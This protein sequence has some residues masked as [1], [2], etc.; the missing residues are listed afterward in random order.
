MCVESNP[1]LP[2]EHPERSFKGGL[3]S[4][5]KEV[6][7]ERARY[8]I[9]QEPSSNV[10][11]VEAPKAFDVHGLVSSHSSERVDGAQAYMQAPQGGINGVV[12]ACSRSPKELGPAELHAYA[13]PL[14]PSTKP[15]TITWIPEGAERSTSR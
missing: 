5:W 12:N 14:S 11:F 8:A 9:F 3:V 15:A 1:E 6:K 13:D 2:K 10:A 4:P 7:D